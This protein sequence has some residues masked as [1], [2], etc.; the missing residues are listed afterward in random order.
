MASVLII[1]PDEADPPERVAE[2]L[3]QE[4]L[5]VSVVRPYCGDAVP[6]ALEED[7]LIVLGGD[8]G[9]HDDAHHPWLTDIKHLLRDGVASETPTWGICLGGQ[10]LA[11]ATGGRVDRGAHG[12]ESGT[13]MVHAL[14][15]A[16]DDVL[17]GGLPASVRMMTM[18]R[19]AITEL[20]AEALWLADSY[21]YPHQAFRLGSSAWGVQFHPEI[22]PKTY[23]VWAEYSTDDGEALQRVIDG[24]PE[25]ERFDEEI[26][27]GAE[28]M[29]RAFARFVKAR[30]IGNSAP[31]AVALD[32]ENA[33]VLTGNG[34]NR[35]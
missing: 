35:G 1:Q 11:A 22:S 5:S 23:R 6:V 14:E 28:A 34:A 27:P 8:M 3:L 29:T 21:P 13:V 15:V 18:H 7:A 31:G 17:F 9:A 2:W 20:P 30:A 26:V 24:L 25:V 10:L 4:N 33:D 32:E 12:M 16:K 19:D